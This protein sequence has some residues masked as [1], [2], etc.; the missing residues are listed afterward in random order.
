MKT[1]KAEA[2]FLPALGI[3]LVILG[4]AGLTFGLFGHWTCGVPPFVMASGGAAMLVVGLV[5][6]KL[7]AK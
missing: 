5:L 6:L 4:G 1:P 2:G 7:F 3:F